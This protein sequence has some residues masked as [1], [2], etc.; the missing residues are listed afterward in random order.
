[1]F[2]AYSFSR[3][4]SVFT[5]MRVGFWLS[6]MVFEY[7]LMKELLIL[8]DCSSLLLPSMNL[9]DSFTLSITNILHW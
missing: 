6:L 1:M 8:N 3:N 9:V 5:E 7:W 2:L 4:V